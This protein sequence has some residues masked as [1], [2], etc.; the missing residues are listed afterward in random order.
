MTKQHIRE[1]KG[2]YLSRWSVC[3]HNRKHIDKILLLADRLVLSNLKPG[4]TLCHECLGE[5]YQGI[6][7]DLA[8]SAGAKTYH[9]LVMINNIVFKYKTIVQISDHIRQLSHHLLDRQGHLI[10]SFQHQYLLYDRVCTTIDQI[11]L[12]MAAAMSDWKLITNTNLWGK[13]PPGYGDFWF[14]FQRT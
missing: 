9:N 2:H 3:K 11:P 12:Q 13:S 10:F 14:C 4:A 7:P 8:C 5:I 6:V 1:L